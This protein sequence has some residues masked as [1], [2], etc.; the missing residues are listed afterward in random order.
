TGKRP[1]RAGMRHNMI[2]PY[3]PYKAKDGYVNLAVQN[4]AQWTRLCAI[5][6]QRLELATNPLYNSNPK[7]TANR[8]ELEKL[9]ED[10]FADSTVAELEERLEKADV[11][12]GRLNELEAVVEHPQ[13]LARGRFIEVEGP[14]G[15]P[16]RV[17]ATP[18][19]LEDLPQ[20]AGP[21]PA[22]G[23]HN[24]EIL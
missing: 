23:Q 7:R 12:F 15:Q 21:V 1:G 16:L 20:R 22:L 6:L 5:V 13:L 24:A 11:P 2:V 8:A 4:E 14:E 3:G 9:I 10:I 17:L 19:G 18:F